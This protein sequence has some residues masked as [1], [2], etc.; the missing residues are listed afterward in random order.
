MPGTCAS[1]GRSS[2]SA[3]ASSSVNR[4]RRDAPAD[5]MAGPYELYL[6]RHGVAEERGD[7]RPDDSK[8]PLTD[9]G[10]SRL[11]KSARGLARA[12]VAFHAL[13]TSPLLRARQTAEVI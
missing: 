8:R 5:A 9:H 10:M 12:G 2:R 7:A 3:I 4:P 6:I 11:R 1:V 13:L